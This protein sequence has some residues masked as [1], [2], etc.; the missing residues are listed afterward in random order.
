MDGKIPRHHLHEALITLGYGEEDVT[1]I[2]IEQNLSPSAAKKEEARKLGRRSLA[3]MSQE[4]L[5][6]PAFHE[7]CQNFDAYYL[8]GAMRKF[9]EA[10]LDGD[11][12]LSSAE[13]AVLLEHQGVTVNPGVVKEIIEEVGM[14]QPGS[15]TCDEF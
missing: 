5:D 3:S 14:A 7:F 15:V 10:D 2:S 13:V 6:Y 9:R 12:S 8:Y 11:G 1:D 4:G